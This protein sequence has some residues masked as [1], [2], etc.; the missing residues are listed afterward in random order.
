MGFHDFSEIFLHS[1]DFEKEVFAPLSIFK[2]RE[3]VEANKAQ[4]IDDQTISGIH[5]QACRL[6]S[7]RF[8]LFS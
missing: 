2:K 7:V 8:F 3:T 1:A 6:F 5:A 4:P